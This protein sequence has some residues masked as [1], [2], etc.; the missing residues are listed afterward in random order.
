[1]A[2]VIALV[3]PGITALIFLY[4]LAAWAVVT[5]V[6]E[7]VAAFSPARDVS[8][9]RESS[10][11]DWWLALAGVASIIFGV[12]I[13]LLPRFGLLSVIWIIGI[14]ALIFGILFVVRFFQSR[15]LAQTARDAHG[16]RLA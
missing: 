10:G 5:G 16:S 15:V 12:I 13:A 11:N 14:Y 2:G 6:M 8:A 7:I 9:T 1:V 4:L 3:W